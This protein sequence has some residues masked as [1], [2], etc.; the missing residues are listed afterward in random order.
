MSIAKRGTGLWQRNFLFTGI[1]LICGIIPFVSISLASGFPLTWQLKHEAFHAV[2]ETLGC[3]LALGI[4]GFLLMR[5]GEKGNEYKLWLAC[6]ML[7][8]AIL[9]AFHASLAPSREFICLHSTAQFIGGVFVALIWLPERLARTRIAK[10]LPKALVAA[11]GLF[12]VISLVFPEIL[13]T[14]MS[15]GRFTFVPQMLNIMGGIL[16]FAGLA[17]FA[18]RFSRDQDTTHL[19]FTAYCLM[20]AV[21]GVTFGLSGL[22]GAGWW[23]SHLIRLGAYVVAFSYVSINTAAEYLRLTQT[24]EAV[25]RLAAI[26]ESSDDAIIGKVLDGTI[27][28]W[29]L[30]AKN[31]YGYSAEEAQGQSGSFLVP[32]DRLDEEVK[33]LGKIKKGQR[34]DCFETVRKKKDGELIDVSLSISPIEDSHGKTIGISTIARDITERKQAEEELERLNK[35]LESA[36]RELKRV[37]KELQEFAHIAAHDLKAP[38]RSIRTLAYWISTDYADKFDERGKKQVQ[39]LVK[40]VRQMS[41]LIDDILQYS[42]LGQSDPKKEQ[43]DLNTVLSE[44]IA[45]IDPPENIEVTV[46]N[47]LPVLMCEKT[48]MIQVFQNLLSNAVKYM[49]KPKGQIKVGCV[50]QEGFWKFS[51]SDNG[52]GIDEK[53]FEK[54]FNMFQTL[55]PQDGVE[56]TGIGLSTV[57]KIAELNGGRVWVESEVGKGSTFLFTLPKQK[58][59][60]LA[61]EEPKC[62]NVC[63][64]K[65]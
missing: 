38:L 6:S 39:H 34:V 36:V 5:Q 61:S 28:S 40:R 10:Q 22:W 30:G 17:Y 45:G 50:E 49:D 21:S 2:M 16:F 59:G 12:G 25:M 3:M 63:F 4:A 65:G 55:S 52:P 13:P 64:V 56:S 46:E 58:V 57:K 9:D 19:L 14:M 23:L 47:K 24:E 48:Q 11:A 29:N 44:E 27:V 32:P 31:I 43:V 42:R 54:I 33:I 26:V 62:V 53:Y 41:A 37:N 8:M 20:F 18:H 60:K 15:N 7:S 1:L 51:V 35:H